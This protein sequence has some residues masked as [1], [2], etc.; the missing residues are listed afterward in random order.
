MC[1]HCQCSG[2]C[3]LCE[4]L[5]HSRMSLS[6]DQPQQTG[7]DWS[8]QGKVPEG[9]APVVGELQGAMGWK[10]RG[11]AEQPLGCFCVFKACLQFFSRQDPGWTAV[12]QS[13]CSS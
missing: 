5:G 1:P 9:S 7:S 3:G 8:L 10:P 4:Q 2:D 11:S 13:L 12:P 6:Q